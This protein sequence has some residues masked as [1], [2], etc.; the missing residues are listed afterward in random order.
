MRLWQASEWWF[1]DEGTNGEYVS[2]DVWS[3]NAALTSLKVMICGWQVWCWASFVHFFISGVR[4][5]KERDSLRGGPQRCCL[6]RHLIRALSLSFMILR[7]TYVK[8]GWLCTSFV[9][10]FICDECLWQDGSVFGWEW[11]WR[12]ALGLYN[13]M[14]SRGRHSSVSLSFPNRN[15]EEA[16][17][18]RMISKGWQ[19]CSNFDRLSTWI[20][21][22]SQLEIILHRRFSVMLPQ[23]SWTWI[24]SSPKG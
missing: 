15:S 11:G 4:S 6:S 21:E 24:Y 10:Y 3:S 9:Y 2:W 7:I 17:G 23:M 19:C 14:C 1:V 22:R 18:G 12:S 20:R 5:H 8:E 16:I 13:S